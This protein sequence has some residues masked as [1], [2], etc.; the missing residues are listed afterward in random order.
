VR[1]GREEWR[2]V[3]VGWQRERP[4]RVGAATHAALLTF[5][6]APNPRPVATKHNQLQHTPRMWLGPHLPGSSGR[7]AVLE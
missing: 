1:N 4:N 6:L 2:A 5:R 3:A 7:I